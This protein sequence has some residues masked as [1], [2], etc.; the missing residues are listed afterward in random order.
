[1]TAEVPRRPIAG[2]V[3]YALKSWAL[4]VWFYVLRSPRCSWTGPVPLLL[5]TAPLTLFRFAG[6]IIPGSHIFLAVCRMPPQCPHVAAK[7]F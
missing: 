1:M 5:A 6:A 3:P 4:C 2:H 7:C